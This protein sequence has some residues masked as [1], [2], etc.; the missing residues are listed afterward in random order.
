M[1]TDPARIPVIIG[2]GQIND[3]ESQ[4]DSLELMLQ[5]LDAADKDAG[6]GWIAR[7]DSLAVV[8]QISFAQL[9][10]CAEKMVER[11]GI[12]PGHVEQTPHP[13]GESPVQ[14]LHEAA[15]RIGAGEISVA[16]IV[17]AEA[18]R[19]AAANVPRRRQAKSMTRCVPVPGRIIPRC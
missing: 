10:N 2:T 11:L 6:G 1:N 17:G 7:L 16:A 15:N 13:T 9:G 12:T 3:R 19:T 18:L 5:A 4:Y 14:L 8:N